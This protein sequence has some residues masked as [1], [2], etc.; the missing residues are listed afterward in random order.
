[1][2][3]VNGMGFEAGVVPPESPHPQN[4]SERAIGERENLR[5]ERTESGP[6]SITAPPDF[7]RSVPRLPPRTNAFLPI[8]HRVLHHR[9]FGTS[10][11]LFL[12]FTGSRLWHGQPGKPSRIVE[13]GGRKNDEHCQKYDLEIDKSGLVL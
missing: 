8:L 5:T 10:N 13:C 2:V 6:E 9:M 7:A 11:T 4:P 3:T 1:M 12:L